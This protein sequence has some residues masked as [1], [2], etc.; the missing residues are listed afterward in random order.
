MN[1]VRDLTHVVRSA[2]P[3][4]H[5]LLAYIQCGHKGLRSGA[6]FRGKLPML[7]PAC[8]DKMKGKP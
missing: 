6:I 5:M 8:V 2:T 1:N 3:T 7:C 4:A